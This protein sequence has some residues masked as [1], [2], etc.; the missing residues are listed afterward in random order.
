MKKRKG[1]FE[2]IPP[3]LPEDQI[4]QQSLTAGRNIN[5]SQ[6][7]FESSGQQKR[8]IQLGASSLAVNAN[9]QNIIREAD[10]YYIKMSSREN[11]RE[12]LAKM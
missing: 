6:Y 4:Q 1:K 7:K 11:S 9:Q 3:L 8:L 2:R 12:R 5:D 10:D